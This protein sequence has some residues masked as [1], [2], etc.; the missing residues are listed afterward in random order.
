MAQRHGIAMLMLHYGTPR[1]QEAR[2]RLSEALPD[3]EIGQ[4]DELGVF[5][6]G[7]DADD[8]EH[9][10]ERVWDGVAASGSDDYIVFLEHPELPEYWRPRSGR[11]ER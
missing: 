3:A 1:D 6:I 4:P 2:R 8:Q 5:E 10:L 7:L 11:P 9:A